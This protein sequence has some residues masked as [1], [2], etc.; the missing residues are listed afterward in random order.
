MPG[1]DSPP[2]N[3]LTSVLSSTTVSTTWISPPPADRNG[4]IVFFILVLKDVQFNTSTVTGNTSDFSYMF[5]GLHE[6]T[7]YTLE[8]AAATSAGL[9]PFGSPTT[10]VTKED[11]TD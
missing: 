10:F 9:G 2:M 4:Q 6:Y 8:I 3:I 7:Q 11:G 1:P 5:T